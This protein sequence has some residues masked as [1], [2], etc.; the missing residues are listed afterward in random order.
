MN[1]DKDRFIKV[2][3]LHAGGDGCLPRA[4]HVASRAVG[5]AG[6]SAET[7]VEDL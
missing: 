5:G 1:F 6:L 3:E 4:I 7:I 2:F